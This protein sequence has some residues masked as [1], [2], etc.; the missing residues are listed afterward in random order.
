[1]HRSS[2][3]I[4][5]GKRILFGKSKTNRTNKVPACASFSPDFY[6]SCDSCLNHTWT[7]RKTKHK[8]YPLATKPCACF[9]LFTTSPSFSLETDTSKD[10]LSIAP[11]QLELLSTFICELTV[12]STNEYFHLRNVFSFNSYFFLSMISFFFFCCII[13]FCLCEVKTLRISWPIRTKVFVHLLSWNMCAFSV[14]FFRREISFC[15]WGKINVFF[16]VLFRRQICFPFTLF[17]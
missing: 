12:E 6:L 4:I 17:C 15:S 7:D 2:W 16:T 13:F 11:C 5:A 1:M 8:M 9:L 10:N 3:N 14:F